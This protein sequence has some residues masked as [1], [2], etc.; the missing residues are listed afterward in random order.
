MLQLVQ[1]ASYYIFDHFVLCL[2]LEFWIIHYIEG[3]D[4]RCKDNKP[5]NES[6]SGDDEEK[7]KD[8]EDHCNL[9]WEF[10]QQLATSYQ[11]ALHVY[12]YEIILHMPY[13]KCS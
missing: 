1:H 13:K 10:D 4:N 9:H 6:S 7:E 8:D 12:M 3:N 5:E 11:V 2:N